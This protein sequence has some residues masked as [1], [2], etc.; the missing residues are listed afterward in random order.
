MPECTI[1]NNNYPNDCIRTTDDGKVVCC[2]CKE[3]KRP[4]IWTVTSKHSP[5]K[6]AEYLPPKV[7]WSTEPKKD[8][9]SRP[10]EGTTKQT[11]LEDFFGT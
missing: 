11:D 3:I 7:V 2:Y 9:S 5:P 10:I 8:E 4:T 1:C 6:I